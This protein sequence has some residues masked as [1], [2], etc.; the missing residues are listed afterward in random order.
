MQKYFISKDD[1]NNLRITSD[2]VFH[3]RTVLRGRIGDIIMVS[4]ESKSYMVKITNINNNEVSFEILNEQIGN[5]E[6]P[7]FVSI[8]QGY[9]KG[10]KLED[11]IKHGTELGAYEF[12]PTLMKRSVFKLD[13]KK[14]E[15]KL[16]RFNKIAKEAAEQSFRGIV[17]KVVDIKTLK[18][19]DFSSYDKK[20]LCYEESAKNNE[21][22][23]FK[24]VV[25]D[26]KEKDKVA[27]VIGPEGGI[28]DNERDYLLKQDF[29]LCALGP[30]ILRTETAVFYVLS[31]I[32]YEMELKK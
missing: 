7:V 2:D 3:I 11:I 15:S 20:I 16:I 6:L 8:F 13:P 31:A 30:R 12:I 9:P 19:I 24:T 4:D 18:E 14:K 22:K 1:L 23:A 17:P 5:N 29:T 25:S 28:D 27:V 26:L 10:D 21:L 32:S